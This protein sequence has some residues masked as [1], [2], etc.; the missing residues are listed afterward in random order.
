MLKT[1]HFAAAGLTA[2]VA[3]LATAPLSAAVAADLIRSP[4][5]VSTPQYGNLDMAIATDDWTGFYV[6]AHGGAATAERFGEDSTAWGGGVQAGYLHQLGNFVL[7]G[8]IQ[9]TLHN[10]LNYALVPGVAGLQQNWSVEARGRAGVALDQTLLYGTAGLSLA[11]LEGTGGAVTSE[12]THVGAAFGAGIE[13]GFGNGWSVRAE[14]I[15]TRFWDVQS[16]VGGV[17][18]SDDLTGHAITA[19]VNYRF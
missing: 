17:S 1:S 3:T 12:D 11:G 18:R 16:T 8:E 14:Y 13:Q 6:G 2:L 19:G 7:G 4:V 9:G 10:E 5:P 15:Q